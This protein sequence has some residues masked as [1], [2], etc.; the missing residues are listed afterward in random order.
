MPYTIRRGQSG[1]LEAAPRLV[2]RQ[3]IS[4]DTGRQEPVEASSLVVAG[5]YDGFSNDEVT[6][7]D[8]QGFHPS[9]S[10]HVVPV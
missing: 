7:N 8:K 9:R 3:V 2:V 1:G 5:P 4:F 10:C 6:L